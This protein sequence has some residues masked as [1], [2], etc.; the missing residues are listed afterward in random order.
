MSEPFTV[1]FNIEL[2]EL[3]ICLGHI[4]YTVYNSEYERDIDRKDTYER[5][6]EREYH[7]QAEDEYKQVDYA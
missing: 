3:F 4:E 5:E 2:L 7:E 6:E 1:S